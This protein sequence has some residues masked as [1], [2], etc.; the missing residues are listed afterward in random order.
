MAIRHGSPR[1]EP[2]KPTSRISLLSLGGPGKINETRDKTVEHVYT[3][4]EYFNDKRPGH[5]SLADAERARDEAR[6]LVK[7]SLHPR[8]C[9][10][11]QRREKRA[12]R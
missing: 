4:G 10:Q 6:V 5:I 11:E 3:I 7:Q 8:Y 12:D 1:S 9:K 2:D